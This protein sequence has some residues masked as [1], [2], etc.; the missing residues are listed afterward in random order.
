MWVIL[1]LSGCHKED[2]Y[3]YQDTRRWVE[4][5][6]AVV[7]PTSDPIMKTRLQRTAEWM[8]QS[9][10]NAQLHDT[11]CI[12]LKLEWYDE[13]TEDMATLGEELASR[14]DVMAIIGPFDNDRANRLAPYCQRTNKPLI[15]P[16]A[17]SESL[18]RRFAIT[19]TGNGQQPFLWSLT[20]TDISLS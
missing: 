7:A 20:E 8:Q 12:N 19:S 18:I 2:V 15:L 5:T 4:K 16:T 11:L 13:L 17:T 1:L 9:L 14:D 10:H 3:I 6:V